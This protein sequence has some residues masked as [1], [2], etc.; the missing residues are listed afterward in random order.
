[1]KLPFVSEMIAES[2]WRATG[3]TRD[4]RPNAVLTRL[5]VEKYCVMAKYTCQ[6]HG[7]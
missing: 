7:G 3:W 6:E 4:T 1:M 5:C 2:M